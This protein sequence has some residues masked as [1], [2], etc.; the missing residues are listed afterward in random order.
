MCVDIYVRKYIYTDMLVCIYAFPKH[1]VIN[2][3]LAFVPHNA[4]CVCQNCTYNSHLT[5]FCVFTMTLSVGSLTAPQLDL[6]A[7]MRDFPRGG[8]NKVFF[9][10]SSSLLSVHL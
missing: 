1:T 10:S 2:V 5:A 9:F 3:L 6:A 7:V 8:V 4:Y